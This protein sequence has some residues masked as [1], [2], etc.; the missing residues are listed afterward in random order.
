[1]PLLGLHP[2]GT[3]AQVTPNLIQE[4]PQQYYPQ[5]LRTTV[6]LVEYQKNINYD[7]H[8]MH[9]MCEQSL[10]FEMYMHFFV[11]ALYFS[12]KIKMLEITVT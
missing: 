2:P 7:I 5:R 12:L 4:E 9:C 3:Q 10:S 11:H 8:A 6:T 1:M